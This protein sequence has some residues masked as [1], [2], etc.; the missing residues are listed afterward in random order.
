MNAQPPQERD[1]LTVSQLNAIIK[2]ILDS[3]PLLARVMV[4]GE[5]SNFKYHTQSG[6]LYMTLK[7]EKS[8]VRAVMFA[9]SAKKL[10]FRPE[11]GMKV[12]VE[13]RVAVFERDGQYQLYLTGMQPDGVGA[14]H[15]AYEQLKRKLEAEGLFAQ[16]RKKPLPKTPLHVGVIT[17]S[18]G[19]AVRDI[20]H[21]LGRRFPAAKVLLYPVLV[22]GPDA[23]PMLVQALRWFN[24]QRAA[25]VLIVGRGGGSI[26]D[27]WAF[28]DEGVARAIAAS[29]IPVIS[30]VGHE[31]DFTIADFVADLRAPTPSAAAELAVPDALT[32][33]QRF[34]NVNVRMADLLLR[35]AVTNRARLQALSG[36]RTLQNPEKLLDDRKLVLDALSQRAAQA[37]QARLE[38]ARQN[39]GLLAGKLSALSP[40]A[41]LE[42]GYAIAMKQGRP[43][44]EAASL[45]VGDTLV[46]R[47]A[48]GQAQASVTQIEETAAK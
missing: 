11:S 42:R 14:L 26:E 40:L 10:L 21:V 37:Q 34:S 4:R 8:A 6:H 7:D 5:L 43:V 39:L 2:A 45:A 19:A 23:P 33:R 38:R 48:K 31:T 1:I 20:I 44:K 25:D 28:N 3:D 29:D 17:A 30:A 35:K 46:L 18:T 13:G 22:Q 36:H 41:V 47:F 16:S 32:L 24:E 27:L 15:L 9:S 12:I